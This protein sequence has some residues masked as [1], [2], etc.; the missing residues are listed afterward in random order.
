MAESSSSTKLNRI[1]D[2]RTNEN[3]NYPMTGAR[4]VTN[5]LELQDV[6]VIFGIIGGA[7]MPIYDELGKSKQIEQ[8]TTVHEQAAVHAADGYAR[9]TG[10][11]GV[12]CATSGPGAT[13]MVTGI[14]NASMDSSPV[15][16]LTGQ[17]PTGLI[18]SDAF[19]E[20]DTRGISDAI[21]KH[22]YLVQRPGE[23]P[24]AIREA[25]HLCNTGRPGPVLVDLPKDVQV[26][27]FECDE[28]EESHPAP[29]GYQVNSE[30][31]RD[32]A[33]KLIQ[34]LQKAEKPLI[35]T[36]GGVG[37]SGASKQLTK[38]ARDYRIPVTAS[39]M[40]LGT[41]PTDDPLFLG[42]LGMHGTGAANMAISQCDLLVA[43]GTRLDDW[44][45]GKVSEFAANADLVHV[46]IDPSEIGK[47][48]QPRLGILGD[49]RAVLNHLLEEMREIDGPETEDWLLKIRKWKNK[50]PVPKNQEA[51]ALQP[52]TVV[53]EL[54]R[55][56]PQE[57]IVTTGVG[58]HQMWVALLYSF[59]KPRTIIT[60][61][62]L[63][64]MGFGFPAALG[65]KIGAPDR[66]VVC[67]T[68]DGS[69]QMNVQELTTAVKYD[70]DI[71]VVIL[72]NSY[73]GMVRQWQELF[74]DNHLVETDISDGAPSFAELARVYGAS[75]FRVSKEA[76]LESKLLQALQTDGPTIVECLV[77][78]KENVF[79]MVPAGKANQQFIMENTDV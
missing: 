1:E 42:M 57:T 72:R 12:C 54:D 10:K 7:I 45:T 24:T 39:L 55:L 14:A 9:V 60:S 17:V 40:G 18:G 49:A 62:G 20:A 63:G 13:N 23:I 15:V 16:G 52:Q 46:D 50:F 27:S 36:G 32:Q 70:L 78:E 79:P 61:G 4:A 56:T 34:M 73:L 69:F 77:E 28:V 71:T 30:V 26:S 53:E 31:D 59:S 38:F 41:Y 25:F 74:F 37:I 64:T 43:I 21:T 19:Q 8:I 76:N 11:P 44:M 66:P 67:V 48:V 29:E 33:S 5:S 75:G 47:I 2:D 58:Q 51:T 6:E 35:L 68:G 22:N 3:K 65:A